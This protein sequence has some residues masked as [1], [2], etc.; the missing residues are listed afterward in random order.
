MRILFLLIMAVLLAILQVSLSDSTTVSA[1]S[2]DTTKI[3][4]RL[5][6]NTLKP[7]E[8]IKRF[9]EAIKADNLDSL[10]SYLESGFNPDER[11]GRF[12]TN[13]ALDSSS[14]I[15]FAVMRGKF[16]LV[17]LL[18]DYGASLPDPRFVYTALE[19]NHTGILKLLLASGAQTPEDMPGLFLAVGFDSLDLLKKELAKKPDVNACYGGRRTALN[20]AASNGKLDIARALLEAGAD[21]DLACSVGLTPLIWTARAG[22]AD[23]VRLLLE[24]G[25]DPS[26]HGSHG[27]LSPLLF[28]VKKES[29]QMALCLL[30]AGADP[31][32][33]I[34]SHTVVLIESAKTDRMDM[35]RLLL[36][37][38]ADPNIANK[39]GWTAL[40]CAA[41]NGNRNMVQVLLDA[42]AVSLLTNED[43]LTATELSEKNGHPALAEYLRIQ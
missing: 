28:A 35:V 22:K 3:P 5:P 33:K 9:V 34:Y 8:H 18:L 41:W 39:F 11:I 23:A 27:G 30:E 29:D 17:K 31:D 1:N 21:P 37:H 15:N 24:Y 4:F 6:D 38:E 10:R 32:K 13:Q 25:A 14:P 20:L 36:K 43:G 42:G 16:D 7:P 40:M 26:I 19:L 12:L 2:P